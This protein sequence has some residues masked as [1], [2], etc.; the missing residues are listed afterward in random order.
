MYAVATN[1]VYAVRLVVGFYP[2]GPVHESLKSKS[3]LNLCR[4]N[5]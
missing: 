5:A 2:N 4:F 1:K 3:Y